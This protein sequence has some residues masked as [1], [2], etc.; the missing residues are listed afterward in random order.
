MSD[1]HALTGH[2]KKQEIQVVFHIPVSDIN[3][4]VGVGY[5]SAISQEE[6]FTA[7]AVPYLEAD[8]AAEFAE[9][10]AAAKYE[11]VEIVRYNGGLSDAAKLAIIDA[12]Y[13]T[14]VSIIQSQLQNKYIYWGKNQDVS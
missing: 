11:Y 4:E 14:L 8:F 12:R 9:L 5:R 7:S 3:N 13:T 6:P 1:W 10:E 2:E